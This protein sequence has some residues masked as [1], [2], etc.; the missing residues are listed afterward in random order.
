MPDYLSRPHLRY[1][2]TFPIQEKGETYFVIRDPLE[3][4]PSPLIVS[5][6]EFYI[7]NFF[8]GTR[9]IPDIQAEV[10][11]RME[12][13]EIPVDRITKLIDI[14]DTNYFLIG[15]R[16]EIHV[17]QIMDDY[18]RSPVRQAWHAGGS[19]PENPAELNHKIDKFYASPDGAGILNGTVNAGIPEHISAPENWQLQAIMVPHIDLRVGGECYTHAYKPLFESSAA[20]ADLYIIL[21]V[22][23]YGGNGFF[24]TTTKDFQTPLG[25]V[26]TDKDF[27]TRWHENAGTNL[28]QGDWAHRIEHSIEF[29]LPFL[30][31]GLKKPFEIVPVLCG[32]VE[33]F[34]E[35]GKRLEDDAELTGLIKSL[36]KTLAETDKRAVL[37]LSVDLAHMGPKFGD[38][39]DINSEIAQEIQEADYQMFNALS[40]MDSDTFHDIMVKDLIPRKVDACGA[41]YTLLS[42]MDD[43]AGKMVSYDQNFQPDTNSLVSYGSMV[44]WGSGF[45]GKG[46]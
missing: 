12:G 3:I 14:L 43:G 4:S 37:V 29:Q 19:Y 33:P 30:Q 36:K 18:H 15:S 8:D 27:V 46:S 22:A 1:I 25:E 44:F 32:S 9:S 6:V 10:Q 34:I 35:G 39:F 40:R 17:Q 16:F 5:P 38:D 24:T 45:G 26:K 2:D 21:G 20:N 13:L 11:Q 41:A 7:L 23:H 28:S 31:H 42:L